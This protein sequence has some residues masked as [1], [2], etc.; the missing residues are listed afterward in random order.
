MTASVH[1]LNGTDTNGFNQRHQQNNT[2]DLLP[3]HAEVVSA[4][5]L[6]AFDIGVGKGR[7]EGIVDCGFGRVVCCSAATGPAARHG[8]AR[9]TTMGVELHEWERAHARGGNTDACERCTA[10]FKWEDIP[11]QVAE[12]ESMNGDE[13]QIQG[14]GRGCGQAE[15]DVRVTRRRGDE[16]ERDDKR[17]PE[18]TSQTSRVTY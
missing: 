4:D 9:L 12:D 1:D 13:V 18:L 6:P 3:H 5:L 17:L 8:D 2:A 16:D 10:M 7:R 15:T 11:S 14:Q